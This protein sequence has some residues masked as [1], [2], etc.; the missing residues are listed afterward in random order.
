VEPIISLDDYLNLVDSSG[1]VLRI[2]PTDD[3]R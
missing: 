1:R 2:R 3:I